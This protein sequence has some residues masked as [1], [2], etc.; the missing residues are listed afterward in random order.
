MD[1]KTTKS[2]IIPRAHALGYVLPVASNREPVTT[3][4]NTGCGQSSSQ[5]ITL[6]LA[7]SR[8]RCE[9]DRENYN[10]YLASVVLFDIIPTLNKV[11]I[12]PRLSTVQER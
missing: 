1:K 10:I 5:Q 11:I 3:Y 8:V 7:V 12:F 4:V 9:R 6:A 2:D